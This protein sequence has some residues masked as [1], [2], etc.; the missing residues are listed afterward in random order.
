[1][2]TR[3]ERD[4]LGEI[5]VPADALYGA[6]TQRAVENFPISGRRPTRRFLYALAL[7]KRSCA[8][9]NSELG[10]L[11]DE[12]FGAVR[13]GCEEV[14]AG[15][16][17]DQFPIDVYQTGSGTSTN[18]NA[19]EVIATRATQILGGERRIH[20]ND[21]VNRGQS[22]NDVIPTVLHVATATEIDSALIPALHALAQALRAKATE[23]ADVVKSGRTHLMDATPVTLGQ[24]FGAWASQV[25]NGAARAARARDALLPLALGGTAVGTG[26]NRPPEFP[27]IAIDY[28]VQATGLPFREA[29]DHFEAQGAQDAIVEAHGHLST[30]AVS[31]A[32]IANDLRL[33]ASGPRT[34]LAEIGL[35]AVQPGSS[36]MPGKVNPV[37]CEMVAMVAARV[38]GNHTTVTVAG[39]G[40]HLELNT[41]LP[42]LADVALESTGLL[43]NAARTFAERCVVG[44]EAHP[45]RIGSLVERNLMLATALAPEIGYDAAAEIAKEAL[46]SDRSVR[47]VAI[48]RSGLTPDRLEVLLDPRRMLAPEPE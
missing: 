26:L 41:Y 31:L 40:G 42:L 22:S 1:M 46:R 18:M 39:A 11:D 27:R 2:T 29:A 5:A 47:E 32:K 24:E 6:Q 20:P 17:D 48:E 19:N 44:I 16:L 34:G 7:V 12:A 4:S 30:I 33:L 28:L 23:F 15:L 10:L 25:E 13:R 3:I 9:A 14:M 36:I 8:C 35:P 37:L 43:A 38:F 21:D 45:D